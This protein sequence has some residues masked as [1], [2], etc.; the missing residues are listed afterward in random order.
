[1]DILQTASH[2]HSGA[3]HTMKTIIIHP[4]NLA[5]WYFRLNGCF[6]IRNFIIHP[7]EGRKQR[8]EVDIFAVRL[9]YRA[10]LLHDPMQDDQV[11]LS[12]GNRTKVILAEV[13]S[14]TCKLNGPWTNPNN[15]NMQLALAAAGPFPK[16]QNDKI[17]LSLYDYG[18][19]EDDRFMMTLF[20]V[21][22]NKNLGI[23]QKYPRVPQIT[24]DHVLEFI[25]NR[26]VSYKKQKFQHPQW[27][28]TGKKLFDRAMKAANVAEFSYS[29]DITTKKKTAQ[30]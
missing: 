4:E 14:E 9:P 19:F 12:N 29:I 7:D 10:E 5:Y 22:R 27:D 1:M 13:K 26:F 24:W 8:T 18:I 15:Q 16:D 30:R 17:A 21:G 28:D 25:Y 20:C 6:T 3:K 23:Q 2:A 11:F